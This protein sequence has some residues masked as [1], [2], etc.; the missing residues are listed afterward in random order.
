MNKVEPRR[1]AASRSDRH[2]FCGL[3]VLSAFVLPIAAGAQDAGDDDSVAMDEVV[4][5]AEQYV[6]TGSRSANKDD[7]PLVETS[8]SVSVISRDMIDLLNWN[9]LNE[10]MRYVSGATG[11]AF[12]PDE[13]Y[14]WLQVR[15]FDPVQFI[16][17]VRAPI[18][19]VNNTA[20]DLYGFESVEVLKGPA[21]GLYGQAPPGGIV[22][23]TSRRPRDEFAGELEVQL[24]EYD[25]A[26][27]NGDVT[28]ALSDT[29]SARVTALYRDRETQVD[30][31]TSERLFI[32]PAVK[33]QLTPATSL[34]LLGNYQD[35]R[36]ENQSTGFLPAFGTYL[37]N[38]LGTVPV[39]RNL[40]ETGVNFFDRRQFSI[41]YDFSHEFNGSFAIEQNLKYFDVDVDSRAVFGSGLL[42]ADADGTP[43]DFR[44]V[45]RSDFPFNEDIETT[46]IDT[47]AVLKFE[48]GV[49]EHSMLVGIDYRHYVGFSAF[50]FGAAPPIDLFE[51]V[52]DAVIPDGP[53]FP[54]VDASVD[55][56]GLYVQDQIRVDNFIVTLTGRQDYVDTDPENGNE[57]DDDEFSYRVGVNYV[58]ANGLSPYVQTARSF[59]PVQGADFNGNLFE[60]T[61][62]TQYEVGLKYDGRTLAP[63]LDVF[64]SVAAYQIVQ[65]NL[66]TPDPVNVGFNVQTGEVEVQGVELEVAARLNERL[67]LNFAF[68]STDSEVTESNA[69]NLGKSLVAVPDTIVSALVDY[70]IQTG[71]FAGLGAGVGVRHR[72]EQFGDTLNDWPSD[73][74]TV[75]DAIVHYDTE[76]WRLAINANNFTDKT[77]VDRCSSTS[78]C[79]YGTRRLVTGSITRKF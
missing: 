72:G 60:P 59:E 50:G 75:W 70:T 30:F 55:Q 27:I 49:L 4:V 42:D 54:S 66:T 74:V 44:T 53:L 34:T 47:R 19:S 14:D 9:S 28:G 51:P 38:P 45:L 12:G 71:A 37:P 48:T 76:N 68:T 67:T 15:G 69:L 36:L 31:L 1:F 7:I 33:F 63:G 78:N 56:L 79:F 26:Q 24:G 16:D 2:F 13:R 32:A 61:T 23:V 20:V 10:S 65:E 11:E 57:T 77:Y 29:I 8:Q 46:N 39:G 73:S 25:H 43:D 21:S 52:Y 35:D 40:G 22:N 5:V 64:A 18:A 3:A 17:G 58:F 62:G 6:S 41:G